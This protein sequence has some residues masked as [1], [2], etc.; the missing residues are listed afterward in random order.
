MD[1]LEKD[2]LKKDSY[3]DFIKF[4]TNYDYDNDKNIIEAKEYG[5]FDTQSY[6]EIYLLQHFLFEI[7]EYDYSYN[8]NQYFGIEPNTEPNH[9]NKEVQYFEKYYDLNFNILRCFPKEYV[10]ELLEKNFEDRSICYN[11]LVHIELVKYTYHIWN[12]YVGKECSDF[13]YPENEFC[14]LINKINDHL[15]EVANM[16]EKE[17]YDILRNDE[18]PRFDRKKNYIYYTWWLYAYFPLMDNAEN[19]ILKLVDFVYLNDAQDMLLYGIYQM[20]PSRL[21]PFMKD[22]MLKLFQQE[23]DHATGKR[24]CGECFYMW[25]GG[26]GA[27]SQIIRILGKLY[28]NGFDLMADPDLV[29]VFGCE[30]SDGKIGSHIPEIYKIIKEETLGI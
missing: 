13:T 29:D 22:L 27:W 30:T 17:Y 24:V 4:K 1:N 26:T 18:N 14:K 15:F 9:K 5:Y 12:N 8:S 6:G 2:N 19:L 7:Y 21:A 3:Q 11:N 28:N 20:Q 16:D 23:V 25:C 10:L